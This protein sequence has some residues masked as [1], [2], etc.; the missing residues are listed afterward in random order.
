MLILVV[1]L[2]VGKIFVWTIGTILAA[3][4]LTGLI[5]LIVKTVPRHHHP[6]PPPD[7]Y[8]QALHKVVMFFNAQRFSSTKFLYAQLHKLAVKLHQFCNLLNF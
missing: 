3:A 8:T 7:N 1:L 2:S 6:E 5:V 4:F